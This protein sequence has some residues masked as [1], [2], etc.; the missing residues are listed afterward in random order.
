[1][2]TRRWWTDVTA[3]RRCGVAVLAAA[4]WACG[5]GEPPPKAAAPLSDE[6]QGWLELGRPESWRRKAFIQSLQHDQ[7]HAA[8]LDKCRRGKSNP[9]TLWVVFTIDAAGKL[10]DVFARADTLN[11][12]QMTACVLQTMASFSVSPHAVELPLELVM[13]FYLKTDADRPPTR[14]SFKPAATAE[15]P[16]S[17]PPKNVDAAI[18][19]LVYANRSDVAACRAQN[20][21]A[22]GSIAIEIL[23]DADGAIAKLY[24]I[25][26]KLVNP[27]MVNC[28]FD[29]IGGWRFHPGTPGLPATVTHVFD[30]PKR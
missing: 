28:L 21:E 24:V 7:W 6:E 2:A 12:P 18:E 25:E 19:Q 15:P 20:P 10:T 4:L 14:P 11:D 17:K 29:V 5:A 26:D 8:E 23:V 27:K 30:F 3:P 22:I 16:P 1:M 13:E 9:G